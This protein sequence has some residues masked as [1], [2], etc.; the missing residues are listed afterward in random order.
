MKILIAEYASAIGI[1]GTCE[2]EGRAMLSVLAKSFCRCGHKVI[3]PTSRHRIESGKPVFL[4]SENE[5]ERFLRT[6][7]ADAGLLVAPDNLQPHYLEILEEVAFN[8]GCSPPVASLCA[9]KQTCTRKLKE[10]GLPSVDI[11]TVNESRKIGCNLY[12]IK[13]RYGCGSEDVQISSSSKAPDGY[14]ATRYYNGLHM[15]TSFIVGERFLPLTIN[16]QIIKFE[17]ENISYNGSQVPYRT[18]RASEIWNVTEKVASILGLKGYA[19]IDFIVS[20]LPRV[21]DVNARPTT[22]VIGIVKVMK[23]ELADLILR[24]KFGGLP[25]NVKIEGEYIFRKDEIGDPM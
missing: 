10:K 12:V 15:S 9:D 11:A 25:K 1:G 2:L 6:V 24:A 17:D 5:F 14:I 18:P 4:K 7:E 20:D 3:Y 16:R 23:E 22:S 8:L 19:G 13:P 21:V